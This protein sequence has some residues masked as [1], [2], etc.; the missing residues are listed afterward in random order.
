MKRDDTIISQRE[1]HAVLKQALDAEPRPGPAD[2]MTLDELEDVAQEAGIGKERVLQALGRV[3]KRRGLRS[4]LAW[5]V[6]G[7]VLLLGASVLLAGSGMFEGKKTT[8]LLHNENKH[9]AYLFELLSPTEGDCQLAV[10]NRVVA[11]AYCVVRRVRLEPG[12]RTRVRLPRLPKQCPQVWVRT[13]D[14]AN[15]ILQHSA[16]F[17]LPAGIEVDRKGRLDQKGPGHPNMYPAPEAT[18]RPL[19]R[20]K[21]LKRGAR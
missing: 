5:I 6:I 10:V 3:R 16:L 14:P 12:Q 9:R 4:G 18:S 17:T 21:P 8:M 13:F 20:C 19:E 11:D 1:V 15:E 7:G 2:S